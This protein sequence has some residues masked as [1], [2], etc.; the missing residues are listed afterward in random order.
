MRRLRRTRE[1]L[2]SAEPPDDLTEKDD[3]IDSLLADAARLTREFR[4]SV[5]QAS[6]RLRDMSRT[7]EGHGAG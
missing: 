3:E 5:D 6:A 4:A 7:E 1:Q 2:A